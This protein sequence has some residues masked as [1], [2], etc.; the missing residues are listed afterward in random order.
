[1]YLKSDSKWTPHYCLLHHV[2]TV[3]ACPFTSHPSLQ[4]TPCIAQLQVNVVWSLNESLNML[5]SW[6]LSLNFLL[7]QWAGISERSVTLKLLIILIIFQ[8]QTQALL[9]VDIWRNS[10]IDEISSGRIHESE[11]IKRCIPSSGPSGGLLLQA[12]TLGQ[13]VSICISNG[14]GLSCN[15]L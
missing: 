10:W 12:S 5:S 13:F 6:V 8:I 7:I 11:M 1:M 4:W 3:R 2:L 15:W 9:P 14:W